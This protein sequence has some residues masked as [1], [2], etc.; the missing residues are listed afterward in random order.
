MRSW[1]C[2]KNLYF[3]ARNVVYA[4]RSINCFDCPFRYIF[5]NAKLNKVYVSNTN[6]PVNR[7]DWIILLQ[8]YYF[9]PSQCWRNVR[10]NSFVYWVITDL[11]S[12]SHF[13]YTS[14]LENMPIV[15]YK[16]TVIQTGKCTGTSDKLLF[17]CLKCI[18]YVPEIFYT[19]PSNEFGILLK[20][21]PSFLF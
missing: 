13:L 21:Y 1:S 6:F 9:W 16:I 4:C 20:M 3:W 18:L 15:V 7:S 12:S 2:V 17:E 10:S 5:K 19:C 11:K 8:S 14:V